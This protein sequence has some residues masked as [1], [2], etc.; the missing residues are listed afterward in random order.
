MMVT[1]KDIAKLCGVSV[2][3]V[4]RVLSGNDLISPETTLLVA[5]TAEKLGYSPDMTARTLKTNRSDLIGILYDA[6]LTHPFFSG[7]IDAVRARAEEAGF[8][9]LLLSRVK[10]NGRMDYTETALSRRMDGIVVIYA[11]VESENV[12]KLAKGNIPVISIDMYAGQTSAVLSDYRE[13]T[14][15]LTE[16]AVSK[17]HR[18]IA[19]I[20]GQMGYATRER[21]EGFMSTMKAAG[22]EVPEAYIRASAFNDPEECARETEE[23]LTLP[24]PPT[25]ILMPDDYSA[26]NALRILREKGISAPE[27]FSCAGY[28]GIPLSQ[29]MEPQLTTFWQNTEG[30]GRAAVETLLKSIQEGP[31]ASRVITVSGQ[32]IP[33]GTMADLRK[34][35]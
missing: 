17:G 27:Q 30:I 14:R 9:V 34:Q 8:D 26:I 33:G 31:E 19:L 7:I 25:C 22:L 32:L 10:R 29:T 15:I 12:R 6:P 20:H 35:V 24:E 3:T 11:D 21:L 13:G 23:L 18:R 5:K 4:S 2:S 1:M 16:Y 28:A